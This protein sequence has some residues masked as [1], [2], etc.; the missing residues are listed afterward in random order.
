MIRNNDLWHS[1]LRFYVWIHWVSNWLTQWL[2][3]A[4]SRVA[5]ATKK[6]YFC[7]QTPTTGSWYLSA[8]AGTSLCILFTQLPNFVSLQSR[9]KMF[10]YWQCKLESFR[11]TYPSLFNPYHCPASPPLLAIPPSAVSRPEM[12]SRCVFH[13]SLSGQLVHWWLFSV[14][15]F[16]QWMSKKVFLE[17]IKVCNRFFFFQFSS[18]SLRKSSG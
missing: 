12:K 2:W 4:Y 8:M 16:L 5:F 17:R 14:F 9:K 6:F 15:F 18:K 7:W 1:Y 13:C 10:K 11:S 3:P